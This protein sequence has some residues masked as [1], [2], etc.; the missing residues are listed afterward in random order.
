MHGAPAL[1]AGY[2]AG[3]LVW[4]TGA[5]LGLVTIIHSFAAALILI[6]WTGVI[7]L[8]YLAYR[9]W[10]A[11]VGGVRADAARDEAGSGQLFLA[12]LSLTLGNPKVMAFFLA[13]LPT[14]LDLEGISLVEFSRLAALIA[15]I[16]S[17]ILLGYTLLAA[18]MHRLIASRKV[19]R[20]VNRTCGVGLAGAAVAVARQ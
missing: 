9:M 12:G 4:F 19:A 7:Y 1:I 5:A 3:E 2:V 20:L 6:K 16:Q 11:P 13:L 8:L 10:T 15:A 18:R 17:A 14:L